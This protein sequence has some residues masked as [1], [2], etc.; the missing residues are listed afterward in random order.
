MAA[1]VTPVETDIFK[2]LRLFI[3]SVITCPVVRG[4]DNG[5]PAPV[6]GY[7]VLTPL[8]NTRL[9]TNTHDYTDP[10]TATGTADT[11]QST[12]H[13]VQIDCYGESASSWAVTIST[14]FRDRYAFDFMDPTVAPLYCD[15]P[16]QIPFLDPA[17]S[18]QVPRWMITAH[19]QY[20]PTVSTPQQFFDQATVA[21]IHSAE[22]ETSN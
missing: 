7:I 12:Q 9:A 19:L 18:V 14:L 21:G 2:S 3:L 16:K 1:T 6:G 11:T 10:I 4:L 20:N 8:F 13:S 17:E 5:V 22:T 15:D